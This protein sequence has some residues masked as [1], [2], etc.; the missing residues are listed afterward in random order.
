[1][2]VHHLRL[3]ANKELPADG[4]THEALDL[5]DAGLLKQGQSPTAS[6][7]EHE[8]GTILV[9]TMAHIVL[10][11]GDEPLPIL[12]LLQVAHCVVKEHVPAALHEPNGKLLCESAKVHIGAVGHT[13][14][15]DLLIWIPTLQQQGGPLCDLPLVIA[16]LHSGEERVVLERCVAL[17]QPV[18]VVLGVDKCHMRRGIDEL[19][20]IR[21][22]TGLCQVGP[23]LTAQLPILVDGDGLR[24][25]HSVALRRRVIWLA[26]R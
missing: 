13:R 21:K 9:A 1:M 16:V 26:E 8:L 14:A 22:Q 11:Y 24:D 12:L 10:L 4:K 7:A 20:R 5:G 25:V 17:L 19:L 2:L 6:T 23:P 3:L 15:R 18:D